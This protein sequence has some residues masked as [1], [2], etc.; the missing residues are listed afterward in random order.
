MTDEELHI[1]FKDLMLKCSAYEKTVESQNR[2]IENQDK[3][4]EDLR[5]HI[6]TNLSTIPP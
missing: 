1:K 3:T 6:R 4:I 5:T 2:T